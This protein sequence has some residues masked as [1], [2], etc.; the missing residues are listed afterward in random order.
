MQQQPENAFCNLTDTLNNINNNKFNNGHGENNFMVDDDAMLEEH[1]PQPHDPNVLVLNDDNNN[2]NDNFGGPDLGPETDVDAIDDDFQM[3]AAVAGAVGGNKENTQMEFKETED[4]ADHVDIMNFGEDHSAAIYG[5]LENK[6][7]EE[8]SLQNP[9]LIKG[10]N[11]FADISEE[12]EAVESIVDAVVD[13]FMDNKMME[14]EMQQVEEKFNDFMVEAVEPEAV[15]DEQLN[16]SNEEAAMELQ[17][18]GES[19]V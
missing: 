7:F 4:V 3:N 2:S 9:D 19:Q 16:S 18:T 14:E 5:T 12:V 10:S 17:P 15:V 11:P 1:P 6:I 8:L 13:E